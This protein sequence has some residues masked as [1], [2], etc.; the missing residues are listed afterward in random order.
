MENQKFIELN[1]L[2]LLELQAMLDAE[3]N[4]RYCRK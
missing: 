2:L 3:I 4:A 1:I